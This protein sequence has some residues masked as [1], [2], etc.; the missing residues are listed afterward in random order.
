M[1][2]GGYAQLA[3]EDALPDGSLHRLEALRAVEVVWEAVP[4]GSPLDGG[5]AA[6]LA[7]RSRTG[8]S[9]VGV[10]RDGV[11]LA[12]PGA[13]MTLQAGD[14]LALIGGPREQRCFREHFLTPEGKKAGEACDRS[15]PDPEG[16]AA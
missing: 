13:D 14:L 3:H 12:N 7:I 10:L 6:E 11:M 16:S 15:G 9:V 8:L 4:E 5:T 1:Q 2:G